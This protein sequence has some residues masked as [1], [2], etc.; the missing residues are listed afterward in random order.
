M[1]A[2]TTAHLAWGSEYPI[3]THST[4]EGT[5]MSRTR[6]CMFAL[7][8]GLALA[9]YPVS[10]QE[11]FNEKYMDIGPTIGLGGIGNA[12]VAFGGRFERAIKSLP[13]LND[14]ILGIM[15]GAEYYS[16]SFFDATWS[17][18]PIGATA[19]YHFK[20]ENTKI[21]PFVGAGLGFSIFRCSFSGPLDNFCSGSSELYFIGRAGARYFL[22]NKMALYA[23]VG[24]G[25]S[26]LNVGATFRLR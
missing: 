14:G 26:T 13:D 21:D 5:Y 25:A 8:G 7:L 22:N 12:S 23:D 4:L 9:A 19:N 15:V 16:Y 24:A 18:I 11:G 6:L 17:F 10:A 2:D 1:I 20:L 3:I